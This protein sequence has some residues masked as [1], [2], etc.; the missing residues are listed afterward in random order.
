MSESKV[1][2]PKSK[3]EGRSE[4]GPS[5]S[6]R[7]GLWTLDFG[8]WT[9]T[10]ARQGLTLIEVMLAMTILGIGMSILIYTASQCLGVIRQAKNFETARH[11]LSRVEMEDPLPLREKISEGSESGTF[12]GKESGFRWTRDIALIGEEEDGLYTVT[13]RIFSSERQ[14]KPLEEVV[15]YLYRP[16]KEGE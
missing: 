4:R 5:D 14:E 11:L 12:S 9:R 8:R 3:V 16:K 10:R 2:R 7:S 1:Q 13:T 15:T 6:L